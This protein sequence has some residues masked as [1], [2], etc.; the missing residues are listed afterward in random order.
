[1]KI[2]FFVAVVIL[3]LNIYS[4]TYYY[5]FKQR[6]K[7]WFGKLFPNGVKPYNWSL[8]RETNRI[9]F[10]QSRKLLL[11][12]T[13]IFLVVA[14]ICCNNIS[15]DPLFYLITFTTPTLL[16]LFIGWI[17]GRIR[18]KKEVFKQCD[19]CRISKTTL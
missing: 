10:I 8:S 12:T 14:V 5:I 6:Y 19:K 15:S 11:I 4:V 1:M 18:C 3:A 2:L 13:A 9:M 7:K 17:R 16:S